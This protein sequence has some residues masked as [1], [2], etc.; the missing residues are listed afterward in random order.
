MTSVLKEQSQ[1][2]HT[3]VMAVD[4]HTNPQLAFHSFTI[5]SSDHQ[6]KAGSVYLMEGEHNPDIS[7]HA[8]A[9]RKCNS[10]TQSEHSY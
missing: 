4:N 1:L 9:Q 5:S 8:R 10:K 7:T 3:I 2:A 6:Q